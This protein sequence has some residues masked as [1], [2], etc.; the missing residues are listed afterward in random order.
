MSILKSLK[1]VPE[2]LKP[3]E[4]KCTKL[5]EPPPV[6]YVPT[7]DEVQ[8]EVS[9]LRN[10]K[11]KTMIEKDTTLNFPVGQENGMREAFL[12]HVTMVLDAI[13]K[14]GHFYDYKK[15]EK[16]HKE[17]R[18]AVESARAG[19]A[20]LGGTGTM[21][22]RFCKKKAREAGEK[23]LAKAQDSKSEA[24][25]AKEASELNNDSMKTGFLDDL[26]KAEQA[27]S[28][29][30]GA[31]TAAVSKMFLLY[32]NLLST[33]SKYSWNKIIGKQMESDPYVNLQGDSLEGP[34]GMSREL[35]NDCVMFHLLTSFP[36]N[37]SEQ[38]KYYISNVL[39]KPQRINIR[40]FV[41]RVEQLNAYI[42][43]MTCFYYSPNANASTKP[44]NVPFMEAELGAHV[45][46]MHPLL[47]QDQY[48]M[49]EKGMTPMDM[50]LLLTLL[51][52]IECICTYEKG[53]LDTFEKSDKSSYK[54]EKGKKRPGTNSTV[55]VPKKVHFE[56]HCNLCKK[57]GG[58]HKCR[59]FEKDRKEKSSFRAA[60]KGRYNWNPVNQNF[61][62]L[63]N[64][65]KK[66]EKVLKK[67]GKKGK[68]HRYE[69]S[70][71]NSE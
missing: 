10:Y 6:P 41:R 16:V 15:A 57:H 2:G 36:I 32:S 52:A 69:D 28:T 24:R 1:S 54:G 9:R 64:K 53:K 4:C 8:E 63:T 66:L 23:A 21:S 13:K 60:K 29:A 44:E 5:R 7:K 27:Q 47:W 38:E 56:K 59:R 3:R 42:A 50:H 14:R 70:N 65:I 19:L 34:R 68:K 11:I 58:A 22:K 33:E 49:N 71:S 20:L 61:S 62:Q 48:N 12:M 26:E 31:M 30:K 45:L 37:A 39:K 40:Q 43:Q 46:C 51:E 17:A 25:K 67:S 35:F 18:K 55:R